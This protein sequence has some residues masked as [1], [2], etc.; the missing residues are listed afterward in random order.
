MRTLLLASGSPRCLLHGVRSRNAGDAPADR[1]APIPGER[2]IETPD[3]LVSVDALARELKLN[4]GHHDNQC[5]KANREPDPAGCTCI[6]EAAGHLPEGKED[7][8]VSRV[9]VR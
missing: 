5:P 1:I 6:L 2:V 7:D 9:L 8:H 4:E 3:R